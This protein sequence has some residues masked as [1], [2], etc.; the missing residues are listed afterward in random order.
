MTHGHALG[1]CV[2]PTLSI[3]S[4]GRSSRS[5]PSFVFLH[6]SLALFFCFR[7]RLKL[8]AV[9][10]LIRSV[11]RRIRHIIFVIVAL[12]QDNDG[13]RRRRRSTFPKV[14][15]KIDRI[16]QDSRC[17][18]GKT[19]THSRR[20]KWTGVTNWYYDYEPYDVL[21]MINV[22]VAIAVVA[23][24]L[25]SLGD[26]DMGRRRRQRPVPPGPDPPRP[27]PACSL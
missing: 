20:V 27:C 5:H 11:A 14:N 15:F 25:R 22:A 8:N 9:T 10:R 23:K 6:P 7:W 1:R 17:K 26:V 19:L 4:G 3:E 18:R 13:D 2:T 12:W 16:W 24:D 21:I